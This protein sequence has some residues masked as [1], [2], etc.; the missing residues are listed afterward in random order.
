MHL[1]ELCELLFFFDSYEAY[2][3]Y[4]SVVE[5]HNEKDWYQESRYFYHWINRVRGIW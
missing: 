5:A 1:H 3:V 2:G 4:E